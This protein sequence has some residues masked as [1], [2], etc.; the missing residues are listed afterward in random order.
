MERLSSL[1]SS[2]PGFFRTGL[3]AATFI[4]VNLTLGMAG[5][6]TPTTT[7]TTSPTP[8]P[9]PPAGIPGDNCSNAFVVTS[10]LYL[11]SDVDLGAGY[12]DD[13]SIGN[14]SNGA[15][16]V[17]I[18]PTP[19]ENRPYSIFTRSSDFD[20]LLAVYRGVCPNGTLVAIDDDSGPD[21]TSSIN[22]VP[23]PGESYYAVVDGFRGAT[24][25][26]TF[27]FA[28]STSPI[29]T[30]VPTPDPSIPEASL[31]LLRYGIGNLLGADFSTSASLVAT[32]GSYGAFVWDGETGDLLK[33]L[34]APN[35][36]VS[37]AAISSDGTLLA[38]G[39]TDGRII[40]WNTNTGQILGM[41]NG[42]NA[43][44][45]SILFFPN[46]THLAA[47]YGNETT[48][49]VRVW[50]FAGAP[51]FE[52]LP[53][54]TV[55]AIW[56][57]GTQ[58]ATNSGI[59]DSDSGALIGPRPNGLLSRD[60]L[61]YATL[62]PGV[63]RSVK[64][65]ETSTDSL[66]ADISYGTQDTPAVALS[67]SPHGTAVFVAWNINLFLPAR[68][69][70]SAWWDVDTGNPLG[71]LDGDYT[72]TKAVFSPE[73]SRILL[74]GSTLGGTVY[75]AAGGA[76]LWEL[77][78]HVQGGYSW[79]DVSSD[80]ARFMSSNGNEIFVWDTVTGRCIGR[81]VIVPVTQ[82]RLVRNPS[83]TLG[84]NRVYGVNYKVEQG[85][86]DHTSGYFWDLGLDVTQG[87]WQR[88]GS[89]G[90]LVSF[91]RD[92]SLLAAG[93]D[94][95]SMRL[96]DG[97]AGGLLDTVTA[98]SSPISAIA[99]SSDNTRVLSGASDSDV[100]VW[101]VPAMQ[102]L[103][104]FTGHNGL[105]NAAT[106]SSDT[107]R[108]LTGSV[109]LTAKLWDLSNEDELFTLRGHQA[110]VKSVAL[111]SEA[112]R[113][114]TGSADGTARLWNT[115]TG[116]ELLRY[117]GQSGSIDAVAFMPDGQSI[118]TAA[119]E[120]TVFLRDL[121]GPTATP[122]PSP[123]PSVSP[124]PSR[125][126]TPSPTR[127]PTP[128]ASRTPTPSPTAITL[129]CGDLVAQQ[130]TAGTGTITGILADTQTSDNSYERITEV[131]FNGG[132]LQ[133]QWRFNV[134]E[135]GTKTLYVE[136]YRT[137]S[138]N[139]PFTFS[140][141]TN[142]SQFTDAISVTKSADDNT[143]QSFALPLDLYAGPIHIRV[144]DTNR[145]FGDL[146][147]SSIFIDLIAI[148]SETDC[149]T[150]TP[151]PTQSP[152]PSPTESPTPSP[153]PLNDAIVTS[154][155]IP[156]QIA[157]SHGCPILI[158]ARNTGEAVWTHNMLF[159]LAIT[160]DTCNL[161]PPILLELD[162]SAVVH[163]GEEYTFS[164]ELQASSLPGDCQIGFQMEQHGFLFGEG[165]QSIIH[166][167]EAVNS[168]APISQTIPPRLVPS[169]SMGVGVT[170]QNLGNTT[171]CG[172][173]SFT[174]NV[175]DDTCSMTG[176]TA[177]PVQKGEIVTSGQR[178]QF[179]F[180]VTAPPI[181]TRC[182]LV[183]AM[184]DGN[185]QFGGTLTSVIDIIL[186]VNSALDWAAYE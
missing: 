168:A 4:A 57:D 11:I 86:G 56:P 169:E 30:P 122:S 18:L 83:L 50:Q 49:G 37:A 106:F 91:S 112:T 93:D 185:T 85:L 159:A 170:F 119:S 46:G 33:V 78:D 5:G 141:S 94:F 135:G 65:Y 9:T 71:D 23:T 58:V 164:T 29:Q 54:F 107:L 180:Q 143:P 81:Q 16:A 101:S 12:A 150:P 148:R 132:G 31:P 186:P 102:K 156:D 176:L 28:I 110:A 162:P 158:T 120:G 32:F 151:S 6:Q 116:Q 171:W 165:H 163:P 113:A 36:S 97:A 35:H 175:V 76:L 111:S 124:T 98:H 55:D 13:F 67:L 115:S 114:L 133:H 140:Y 7:P 92:E 72:G 82:D 155:S 63:L 104:S 123:T 179:I 73:D 41:L 153:T 136:A 157:T 25:L 173:S 182:F 105:V 103:M 79:L 109:D 139:E 20:T 47:G 95:G 154:A 10:G 66:L 77:R 90:R 68:V 44:V 43:A 134:T 125:T 96:L 17:W 64:V 128:T 87:V 84:G 15:D 40:L 75:D 118:L 88:T 19:V 99:F 131:L 142:N 24:G 21:F 1:D 52:L 51:T 48:G 108:V 89:L 167:V 145:A 177:I 147:T 45:N 183:F 22:F 2:I 74:I 172:E 149:I 117:V 144:L 100:K 60:G 152:S 161:V 126:P 69:T 27:A 137:G 26:I 129:Q 53:G 62:P 138:D 8:S 42:P 181:E 38:S 166:L 39:G 146:T 174:L 121:N 80:G 184:A 61:R 130:E 127:T 160:T 14:Y 3:L 178:Y 70:E 34:R 59:Y